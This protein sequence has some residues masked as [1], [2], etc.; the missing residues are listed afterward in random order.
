MG[1][2]LEINSYPDRLDLPDVHCKHASEMG[3]TMVISTD[4]HK[5]ADLD[6]MEF[7][8]GVARRG[9]LEK[10]DVLN[11]LPAAALRKRLKR[12]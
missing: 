12:K 11:T 9:W 3:L 8:V 2:C 5:T 7:G 4:S 6:L 10:G 1:V